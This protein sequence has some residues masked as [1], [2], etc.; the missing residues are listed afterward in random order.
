MFA[1]S[2]V[3]SD[4]FLDMPLGARCL[5]MTM[6][7]VADDDGFVN[8]PKSI[9]RQCGASEDDLK[10]LISKSFVIPFDS[11]IIVIKHWRINNYLRKDRY[12]ETNYLEEKSLLRI[13]DN[14]AYTLN[15]Q[16]GIPSG[17]PNM[18]TPSIGKDS[19]DKN[20]INIYVQEFDEVWKLYP[21]KQGKSNAEKSYIKARKDGTSKEDILQG[22]KKYNAYIERNKV[23]SKYIKMGSTWFNQKCWEDN[24]D[25][26]GRNK[27]LTEEKG[28]TTDKEEE[29]DWFFS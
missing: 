29:L 27:R 28:T 16:D 1:K 13:K 3:L 4:A 11:G 14:G 15:K 17:I 22:L 23:E 25:D 8:T 6:S 20:S 9:M 24:Y 18:G 2:I 12:S 7:M 5:Y 19:I 10:V 26:I 21:R